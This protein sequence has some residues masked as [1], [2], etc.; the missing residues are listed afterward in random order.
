MHAGLGGGDDK[1]MRYI[2]TA[3]DK[4]GPPAT[5]KSIKGIPWG[6]VAEVTEMLTLRG[7]GGNLLLVLSLKWS[8]PFSIRLTQKP[9][10]AVAVTREVRRISGSKNNY[11]FSQGP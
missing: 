3:T 7:F 10:E 9:R 1:A 8:L 6:V 2:A 11:N 5:A 4:K